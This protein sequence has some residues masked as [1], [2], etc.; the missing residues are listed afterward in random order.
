MAKKNGYCTNYGN[1]T[2]ADTKKELEV[3]EMQFTCPE[4]GLD[5]Q[6]IKPKPFPLKVVILCVVCIII[7][8]SIIFWPKPDGPKPPVIKDSINPP[9]E[10]VDSNP[11]DTPQYIGNYDLSFGTYH[12]PIKNGKPNGIGGEIVIST[13]C[14][15]PYINDAEG[16]RLGCGDK[17]ENTVF[18]NGKLKSGTILFSDGS[19]KDTDFK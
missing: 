17:I 2:N 6:E 5:L 11:T 3:E 4:C 1:C 14:Y 9:K 10:V 7:V 16:A 8:L 12:G 18:T 19:T 13:D 15:L